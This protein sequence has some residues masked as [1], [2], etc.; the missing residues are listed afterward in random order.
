[1]HENLIYF[2]KWCLQ[3]T[4]IEFHVILLLP[5]CLYSC[6]SARLND[7]H[8]LPSSE[9]LVFKQNVFYYQHEFFLI[10]LR[11]LLSNLWSFQLSALH[12][13]VL[14]ACHV[15]FF[16]LIVTADHIC[17][18]SSGVL[19]LDMT[20]RLSHQPSPSSC[21]FIVDVVK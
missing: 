12:E 21:I 1:M 14:R 18:R 2:N 3:E 17:V 16:G 4:H 13:F 6:C 10:H 11:V 15:V 20:S 9:L 8:F 19:E 5:F 7:F